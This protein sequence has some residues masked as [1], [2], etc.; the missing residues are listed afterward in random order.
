MSESRIAMGF[1]TSAQTHDA[2]RRSAAA[3]A[4]ITSR[5]LAKMFANKLDRMLAVGAPV[6]PGSALAVHAARLTSVAERE[7]LARSLRRTVDKAH[8]RNVSM[9]SAVP[10]HVP[11]ILAAEDR[12]DDITLRLH[13]PRPVSPR[14]IA[15][16]RVLLADGVGPMY[17]YGHGDLEGRLG[18]AL[19]AL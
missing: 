2:S 13:S 11:N 7:T 16:L 8:S 1:L 18:A 19:A 3:R 5:V 14:G 6:S 10:L 12:I 17:R 4:P 9:S 15:R